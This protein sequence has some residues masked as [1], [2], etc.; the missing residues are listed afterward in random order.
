MGD[1][2]SPDKIPAGFGPEDNSICCA[3]QP[4]PL[5]PST[6]SSASMSRRGLTHFEGCGDGRIAFRYNGRTVEHGDRK[7]FH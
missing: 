1:V 6:R 4:F 2:I 5:I 7:K 3:A